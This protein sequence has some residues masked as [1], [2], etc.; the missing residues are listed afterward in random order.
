MPGGP[1]RAHPRSR[2][3]LLFTLLL[4]STAVTA[5]AQLVYQQ[6]MDH[7]SAILPLTLDNDVIRVRCKPPEG[8]A[9]RD[10]NCDVGITGTVLTD[11]RGTSSSDPGQKVLTALRT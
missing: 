8:L 4:T 10:I 5:N 11:Q 9:P 3:S 2:R 6:K 1:H 7:Y